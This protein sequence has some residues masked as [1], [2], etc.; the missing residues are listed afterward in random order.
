MTGLLLIYAPG[1]RAVDPGTK[2][3][4]EIISLNM[5][6]TQLAKIKWITSFSTL[7]RQQ[8]GISTPFWWGRAECWCQRRLSRESGLSF[9]PISRVRRVWRKPGLPLTTPSSKEA[10]LHLPCWGDVRGGFHHY[11]VL[12]GPL[13]LLLVTVR[14]H[15]VYQWGTHIHPSHGGITEALVKSWIFILLFHPCQP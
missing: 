6:P 4:T 10:G 5:S 14:S 8:W 15:G 7:S 13:A 1:T 3:E 9:L 12:S 11:P 2:Q